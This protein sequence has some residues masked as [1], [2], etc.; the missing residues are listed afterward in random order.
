MPPNRAEDQSG[1]Y[2]NP[3][4]DNISIQDVETINQNQATKNMEVHHHPEV[5]KNP[6]KS[7]CWKD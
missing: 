3:P 6:L 4:D 7:I 1:S 2:P 5:E